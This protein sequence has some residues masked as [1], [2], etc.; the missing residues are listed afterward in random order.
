MVASGKPID[1]TAPAGGAGLWPRPR[2][3]RRATALG[4]NYTQWGYVLAGY[5]LWDAGRALWEDAIRPLALPAPWTLAQGELAWLLLCVLLAAVAVGFRYHGLHLYRVAE[6][7]ARDA[8]TPR[9]S[10]WRP[11]EPEWEARAADAAEEDERDLGR[12]AQAQR[13]PVADEGN[14][15]GWVVD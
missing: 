14:P 9:I 11:V 13:A 15:L 5:T 10:V 7:V 3:S 2:L 8:L 1:P 12:R 4:L 6:R